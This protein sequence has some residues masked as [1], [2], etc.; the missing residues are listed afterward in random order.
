MKIGLMKELLAQLRQQGIHDERLLDALA[1]V[2]RERFVDEAL[3][4]Q[5]YE[6]SHYQLV[7][8]RPFHSRILWQK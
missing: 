3:S 7:M 8:G 4:H 2:P 1:L 6:I 5:A